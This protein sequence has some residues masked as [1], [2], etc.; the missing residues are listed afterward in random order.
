MSCPFSP[1]QPGFGHFREPTTCSSVTKI[2]E[3]NSGAVIVVGG[4]AACVAAGWKVRGY[5]A[6]R[7]LSQL[8]Q[9]ADVEI[10]AVKQRG[11]LEIQAV[12][13][14]ADVEIQAAKLRA[15]VEIQAARLRT[16]QAKGLLDLVLHGDY[17]K[18]RATV[19]KDFEAKKRK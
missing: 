13:Q 11:D 12:K 18:Y 9:R 1:K 16:E 6:D 14:R 3:R 5:L 15:D 2:I 8:Q 4:A 17:D 19:A 10:Q 7:Q